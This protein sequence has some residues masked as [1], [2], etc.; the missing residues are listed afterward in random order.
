MGLEGQVASIRR[1]EM[2]REVVED[3]KARVARGE[4]PQCVA[5]QVLTDANSK[6]SMW[7]AI[8]CS[9]S[10]LQGGTESIPS[11]LTAGF[12]GLIQGHGPQIQEKAFA[13]IMEAYPD[14]DA[15]DH[16]FHE[17]KVPYITAIYKEI[18]RNYVVL[19]F[20]LP[21]AADRDVHLKSGVVI[22]KGTTLYMNS[23]AGNHGELLLQRSQAVESA[24]L[25]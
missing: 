12:G 21:H 6:L 4:E 24:D 17:E 14:G 8:K 10:M 2:I 19:P 3:L 20:S 23:D 9:T 18:L 1:T 5:A 16:A 7:N 13:A 25:T 11:H 15:I 22:P